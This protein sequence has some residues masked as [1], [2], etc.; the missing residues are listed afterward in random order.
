VA[1]CNADS[2]IGSP[3]LGAARSDDEVGDGAEGDREKR[4]ADQVIQRSP[5]KWTGLQDNEANHQ[6]QPNECVRNA[7]AHRHSRRLS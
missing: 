7:L 4:C 3:F 2:K 6:T 1:G 5:R